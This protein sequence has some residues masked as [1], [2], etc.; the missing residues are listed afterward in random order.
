MDDITYIVEEINKEYSF[1]IIKPYS[2]SFKKPLNEYP[3]YRI[4]TSNILYADDPRIYLALFCK[5]IIDEILEK[6]K[7]YVPENFLNAFD[8]MENQLITVKQKNDV[9]DLLYE[10]GIQNSTLNFIAS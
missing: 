3:S 5:P 9:I 1:M 8:G 2:V 4:D 6:E 7:N 10:Q